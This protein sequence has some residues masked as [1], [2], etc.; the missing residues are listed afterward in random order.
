MGSFQP[1][2]PEHKRDDIEMSPEQPAKQWNL[3]VH[4]LEESVA[5]AAPTLATTSTA[6]W[7]T[8]AP[9]TAT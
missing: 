7:S 8:P 2:D 5:T 9:R 3:S 4:E 6:S 1:G